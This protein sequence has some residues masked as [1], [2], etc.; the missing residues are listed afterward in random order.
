MLR[1]ADEQR[2][3]PPQ[4]VLEQA[5]R[6]IR[7]ILI[8][9]VGNARTRD[10]VIR[11]E[12]RQFEDAWYDADKIRLSRA[13]IDTAWP[14]MKKVSV[15]SATIADSSALNRASENITMPIDAEISLTPFD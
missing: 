1:T 4:F 8:N 2:V 6:A 10:E 5:R 11:R 3:E 15:A 13:R 9:I 12:M 7:Q 14:R